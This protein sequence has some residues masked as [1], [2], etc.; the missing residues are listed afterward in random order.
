MPELPDVEVFRMYVDTT[1]LHKKIRRA[2]LTDTGLLAGS[3]SAKLKR[4]LKGAAFQATRRHGK[5]L[6][7]HLDTDAW[8]MLHFGMTGGLDYAK[9]DSDLPEH[10]RLVLG[11]DNGFRLVYVNQR[12]LGRIRLA[13]DFD[14]FIA[15]EALGPDA[16]EI[17]RE[18]FVELLSDGRGTLKARLMNQSLIAGLGNVY[19][20]EILFQAEIDPGTSVADVTPDAAADLWRTMRRVLRTAIDR[21]ARPE[22]FP[23]SWLTPHRGEEQC[24]R[25]RGA[26]KQA[27]ISGRTSRYCP[28]CQ[29]S[30]TS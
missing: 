17:G 9:A 7:V 29:S 12:K 2:K 22:Q 19:T 24:P 5:H 3:S 11:F 4:R 6:G 20:D 18:P 23:E 26:L 8:L 16:L 21:R 25:C 27:K 15:E 10:S 13:D 30:P 1:A 14:A 28:A